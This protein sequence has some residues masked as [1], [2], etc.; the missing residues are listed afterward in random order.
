MVGLVP[1]RHWRTQALVMVAA[2]TTT[3]PV[4]DTIATR[5]NSP[6][7]ASDPPS[8]SPNTEVLARQLYGRLPAL[9][10]ARGSCRERPA[11]RSAELAMESWLAA[12]D[13]CPAIRPAGHRA[14][15]RATGRDVCPPGIVTFPCWRRNSGPY[16]RGNFWLVFGMS[17]T[18]PG[19]IRSGFP[20]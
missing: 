13:A 20:I 6:A 18:C 9:G 7:C 17:K 8:T 19:K 1:S 2:V 5:G 16:W 14:G 10:A 11:A 15:A 3:S 4:G 12:M